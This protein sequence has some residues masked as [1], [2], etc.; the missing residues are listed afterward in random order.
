MDHL[1]IKA[2]VELTMSS[3]LGEGIEH[4]V[5][6]S[7]LGAMKPNTIVMG[8]PHLDKDD[9]DADD[10]IDEFLNP[11]SPFATSQF[12]GVFPP[13]GRRSL[14]SDGE[15]EEL[16]LS[17]SE[18]VGVVR[19]LVRMEKNVCLSRHFQHLNRGG[20]L[21]SAAVDLRSFPSVEEETGGGEGRGTG[22]GAGGMFLGPKTSNKKTHLDIWL[23]DFFEFDPGRTDISDTTSLFLLQIACIGTKGSFPNCDLPPLV[24]AINAD[25]PVI[26]AIYGY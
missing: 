9:N 19:G 8:F 16:G 23:V 26:I 25:A 5:R 10:D 22:A 7:G 3:S 6:I 12:E 20:S 2:F 21:F 1:R 17:P 13:L 15:E 11:R 14:D 24:V 4:L 18:Y